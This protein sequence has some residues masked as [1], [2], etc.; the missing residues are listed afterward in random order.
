MD[1]DNEFDDELQDNTSNLSDN[2][3]DDEEFQN[4]NISDDDFFSDQVNHRDDVEWGKEEYEDDCKNSGCCCDDPDDC[5]HGDYDFFESV[6]DKCERMSERKVDP[7]FG[8]S[9]VALNIFNSNKFSDFVEDLKNEG[10][11]DGSKFTEDDTIIASIRDWLIENLDTFNI[12]KE[13]V[14]PLTIDIAKYM[15][16]Q[17]AFAANTEKENQQKK[18]IYSNEDFKD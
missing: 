8:Y 13:D 9:R 2:F 11:Y 12:D 4:S 3:D 10:V 6:Y 17:A 16:N 14:E 7:N 18:D 15:H 5:G 1:I